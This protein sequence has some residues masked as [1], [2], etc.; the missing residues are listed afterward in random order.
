M[1]FAE[2]AIGMDPLF[3]INPRDD[4]WNRW[5]RGP[6]RHYLSFH[7]TR[8]SFPTKAGQSYHDGSFLSYWVHEFLF[9][10]LPFSVFTVIYASLEFLVLVT[11]F[12]SLHDGR[13]R[14]VP[15]LTG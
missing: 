8:K 10:T 5:N 3:E 15:M 11:F 14:V 12:V 9:V 13:G 6:F 7:D 1:I 2:M 4:D